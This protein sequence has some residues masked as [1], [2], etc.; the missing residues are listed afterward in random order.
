MKPPLGTE[1]TSEEAE[2]ASTLVARF[3]L[4][5]GMTLRSC[6]CVAVSK[7]EVVGGQKKMLRATYGVS[8]DDI[9]RRRVRVDA[10]PREGV[11][12]GGGPAGLVVRR[13]DTNGRRRERSSDEREDGRSRAHL[14]SLF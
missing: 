4:F 7:K 9:E 8:E 11:A 5:T 6:I 2:E 13:R 12:P 10:L 1:M 3:W 14:C